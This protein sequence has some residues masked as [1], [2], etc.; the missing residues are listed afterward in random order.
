VPQ[1]PQFAGSSTGTQAPPHT[2]P[3]A[4]LHV[5]AEHTSPG[6]QLVLQLPQWPT[7]FFKS[8]QI[9]PHTVKPKAVHPHAPF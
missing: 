6:R 9:S 3:L 4:Q 5:P 1:L 8:A 2:S 7:S